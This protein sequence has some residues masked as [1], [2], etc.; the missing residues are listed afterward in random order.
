M[1]LRHP[2][3]LRALALGLLVSLGW[4]IGA[5]VAQAMTAPPGEAHKTWLRAKASASDETFEAALDGAAR[6]AH[7]LGAFVEVLAQTLGADLA[8]YFPDALPS[9]AALTAQ[10]LTDWLQQPTLDGVAPPVRFEA[11]SALSSGT[12]ASVGLGTSLGRSAQAWPCSPYPRCKKA[13]V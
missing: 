7:S 13:S 3:F 1:L 10:V 12:T 9:D 6:Q 11:A 4:G 5:P 8:L 2:R